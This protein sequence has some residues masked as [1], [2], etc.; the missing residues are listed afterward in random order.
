MICTRCGKVLE[1]GERFC[2]ACGL[3]TFGAAAEA[4]K[5]LYG[6]DCTQS[7]SMGSAQY[8]VPYQ[9]E[10]TAAVYKAPSPYEAKESGET[11]FF[12][13]GAFMFCLLIIG[14]LSVSTGIFAGLYFSLLGS[15]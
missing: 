11:E 7:D 8:S 15:L 3:D 2:P 1:E 12:G 10:P 13:K 5:P 9:H 14:L 4:P 6:M